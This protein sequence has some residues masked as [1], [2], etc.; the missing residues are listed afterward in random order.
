MDYLHKFR[1][2][3]HYRGY[4]VAKQAPQKEGDRPK[5]F[6]FAPDLALYHKDK[7]VQEIQNFN[8]AVDKYFEVI[9]KTEDNKPT[10]EDIAWKKFE[11]IKQDQMSRINKLQAE[12]DEFMVKA[13]L[14]EEN[15]DE[16]QAIID[17]VN[18]LVG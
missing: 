3:T 5:Y 7:F 17:L 15:L 13:R 8:E 2:Q 4:L 10:I 18:G 12:Q 11:N 9:D 1:Q 6:D 16:V 14:I